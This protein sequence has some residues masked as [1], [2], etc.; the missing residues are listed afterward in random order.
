MDA[1]AEACPEF[2]R[3]PTGSSHAVADHGRDN[4]ARWRPAVGCRIT[5][6]LW[7]AVAAAAVPISARADVLIGTNGERFVG[8]VIE[9]TTDA[10][11]F[12]SEL[13]GRLTLPRSQVREVQ[14]S[15][16]GDDQET[17]TP[18]VVPSEA[19]K[20]QVLGN[21]EWR[22]PG[23]GQDKSDWIQLKSGEW[24]RGQIQYIQEKE[25][26]FDSDELEEQTF[27]LKDVRRLYSADAM[28]ARFEGR[29][30]V[31]GKIEIGDELVT[32]LGAEP[33]SLPR[34]DLAGITQY[35]GITG[36]NDWSGKF[37]LGA[38][39]QSGNTRQNT[40]NTSAELARR[41]PDTRLLVNFLGNVSKTNGVTVTD[42]QRVNT[43]YDIRI[44]RS[45]FA[46]PV[47]AEYYR[48]SQANIASRLTA[49]V[50]LGYYI[51]DR[52]DL[53]WSVSAG[54][55]YQYTKFA[56]VEAGQAD[57]SGTPA[58]ALQSRY[59]VDVTSRLTFLQTTD[60]TFTNAESGKYT[61]HA[62]TTLEYE[63][64]RHLNLDISFIW[65]YIENPQPKADGVL[66]YR[67]DYYTTI[68]VGLKF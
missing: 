67:S 56:N 43:T 9:E 37:N 46:R 1:I 31:L 55:S 23:V 28:F 20:P 33:I 47:Q 66:P 64:K 40:V 38:S 12:E 42:N 22:P 21:L 41:S 36:I 16:P 61:H 50:A 44:S 25:V 3:W 48:D 53:E 57:S 5:L 60:A 65:D 58:A 15:T 17:G 11:V 10:V 32:V 29:E 68:S 30:P 59:K 14:R 13:S 51:F 45:W 34:D 54:P 24:L 39:L 63:I 4:A 62:V 49:G 35:G 27:K 2:M 26:V 8:K 18:S 6:G 7:L 52:D 19:P